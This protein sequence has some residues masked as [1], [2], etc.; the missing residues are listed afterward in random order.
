MYAFRKPFTAASFNG[1]TYWHTSYKVWLVTAQVLG[2]MFSKFYGI[3]FISA[4]QA[5]KRAVSIVLLITAA[6]I[7]LL[8]FALVPAPYNIIFLFL[9]GFPLGMVWGLV[10]GYLEGRRTT[11]VM[12][13]VLCV[14]FILSSGVVKSVGKFLLVNHYVSD[15]WMPFVTG[16]LFYIP[17]LLF[18]WLLNHLPPPSEEDKRL[19]SPRQP[20]TAGERTAFTRRFLPGLILIV[21]TYVLLTALRDFRDNFANEIFTEMG[22]GGQPAVFTATELPV[23]VIVLV[24]LSLMILI[25]NNF[26]AFMVNHFII[27]VGFAL[28]LLATWLFGAH[29]IGPVMWMIIVGTG[30][31]LSYI[32][33]NCLYFE[34]MIASYRIA[35]NAGFLI[36]IADSFGYLGSV[37]VLFIREFLGVELSWTHFFMYAVSIIGVIGAGGTFLMYLYFKKQYSSV[38][39]KA[40]AVYA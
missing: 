14:N 4:M 33:F 11:E 13:A 9:N 35:G 40:K 22:Y 2:Y 20:M 38:D 18:T 10:F 39:S 5:D 17:M 30:L 12:G 3:R 1:L 16:A 6:W 34:R 23:S 7:F 24:S 31:Y 21:I 32:P 25:K 8:L 28:A 26:K 36:Y 37:T 19:R 15:W 27:M 29:L